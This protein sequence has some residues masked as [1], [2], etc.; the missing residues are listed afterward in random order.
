M[1]VFLIISITFFS[2]LSTIF[3]KEIRFTGAPLSRSI[4]NESN[5]AI[6]R[7]TD[8]LLSQ[9]NN[10][11]YWGNSD[12]KLTSVITLA[13]AGSTPEMRKNPQISKAIEWLKGQTNRPN[14][15]STDQALLWHNMALAIFAPETPCA[16]PAICSKK[17]PPQKTIYAIGEALQLR[18]LTNNITFSKAYTNDLVYL[19]Q[20][21]TTKI[22]QAQE[23]VAKLWIKSKDI[24]N[25][26]KEDAELAWWYSH[27]INK[28]CNGE[29]HIQSKDALIP[30][31]WRVPL[32]N[33]WTTT[34]LMDSSGRGNWKNSQ[35]E[36]AFAIL[37]L[38]EL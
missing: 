17:T 10:D 20:I 22:N 30:I 28:A 26:W 32:A 37:L 3:A 12:L 6:D 24:P 16:L 35:L 31:D 13:I 34:Q 1:K 14:S 33:H 2:L 27:A 19:S 21:G 8:W 23:E 4:Q 5:A 29:L 15:H 7:A 36:T 18:G 11:G 9:Q 25:E 38:S